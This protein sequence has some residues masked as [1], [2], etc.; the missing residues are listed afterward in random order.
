MED[1]GF[2]VW[3]TQKAKY[4]QWNYIKVLF[5]QLPY[6]FDL[7]HTNKIEFT[8]Y[9]PGTYYFDNIKVLRENL[10]YQSFEPEKRGLPIKTDEFGWGWGN[11]TVVSLSNDQAHEG[12]YSWK[13]V[14]KEKYAG[15]GIKSEQQYYLG[16]DEDDKLQN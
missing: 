5:S 16:E 14:L 7:E 4:G 2:E 11:N 6:D 13:F 15:T 3:T 12:E 1:S 8:N 10:I 9:W